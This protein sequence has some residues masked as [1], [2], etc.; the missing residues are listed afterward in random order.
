MNAFNVK[1][2]HTSMICLSRKSLSDKSWCY[3]LTTIS[4]ATINNST[5]LT[6]TIEI[7]QYKKLTQKGNTLFWRIRI[8]KDQNRRSEIRHLFMSYEKVKIME[9]IPFLHYCYPVLTVLSQQN[10]WDLYMDHPEVPW[11][12]QTWDSKLISGRNGMKGCLKSVHF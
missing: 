9:T 1:H 11:N 6:E 10:S 2:F 4:G 5:A 3:F 7:Y 12:F 8:P